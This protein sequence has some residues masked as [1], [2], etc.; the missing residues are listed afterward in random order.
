MR[1]PKPTT[2]AANGTLSISITTVSQTFS[3]TPVIPATS[4]SNSKAKK[5][6]TLP[7][8]K[9]STCSEKPSAHNSC[10]VDITQ[11][12]M[13]LPHSKTLSRWRWQQ[14]NPPGFGVRQPHAALAVPSLGFQRFHACLKYWKYLLYNGQPSL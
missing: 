6:R 1:R 9:V 3:L 13:G 14:L 5:I 7:S 11:S 10:R 12:G 2:A 4:H 8:R